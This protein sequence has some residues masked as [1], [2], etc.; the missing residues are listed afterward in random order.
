MSPAPAEDWRTVLEAAQ[1]LKRSPKT[2]RNLVS[3][4]QL[5]RKIIRQGRARRRVMVLSASTVA[6]LQ[7][8][9]WWG[10]SKP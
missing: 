9:C 1:F 4:H 10:P 6:Q 2:I 3:K 8:L 5:P 7:R